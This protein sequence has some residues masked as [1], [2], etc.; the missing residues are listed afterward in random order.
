MISVIIPVYKNKQLFLDNL[1]ANLQYLKNTQIIVVNDNP[2]D[3]LVGAVEKV[4]NR[5]LVIN[6][7]RNLGFGPS[8]NLGAH[9]AHGQFLLLLNSDVKLRDAGFQKTLALF[10]NNQLFALT[11]AQEDQNGRLSVA[12]QGHFAQGLFHH[13][14]KPCATT[15][16]TLWAE[17]GS[18]L[19]RKELFAKLGGFDSIYAPFYWE[20]VD[21]GYRAWQA[22]YQ[23]LFYPQ[24]I[25]KHVHQT[26][27]NKYFPPDFVQTIAYRN[28][29]LFVWKNMQGL[30]LWQHYLWLPVLLLRNRRNKLFL[31]G[32]RQAIN[33]FFRQQ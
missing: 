6:N 11:F 32:F 28:Q 8:V 10:N 26:T 20:D 7:P 16:E 30:Q 3:D 5:A 24:V 13:Q 15:C 1:K 22:G 9:K 12:N 17:G 31:A 18:C 23:I 33:R 2:D 4:A 29:F 19:I 25:M 21:L 14:S 27:I